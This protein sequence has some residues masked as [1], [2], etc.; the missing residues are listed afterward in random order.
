V[1]VPPVYLSFSGAEAL[2][3]CFRLG[4]SAAEIG[5]QRPTSGQC[6]QG[7][8]SRRGDAAELLRLSA[9]KELSHFDPLIPA[10]S[11]TEK[12]RSILIRQH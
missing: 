11:R 10:F 2:P 3:R 8:G 6:R 4:G 5:E 12:E 1:P 9:E 7:S